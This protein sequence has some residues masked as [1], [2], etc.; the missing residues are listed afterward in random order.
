M[1]NSANIKE[2]KKVVCP[3]CGTP[4][5]TFYMKGALCKGVFFKCKNKT[6]KKQFELRL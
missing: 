5:N 1:D 2:M 3:Y 6:C 4:V